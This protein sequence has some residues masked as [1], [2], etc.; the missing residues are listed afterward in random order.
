M[1]KKPEKPP[2]Q[3]LGERTIQYGI[4]L[5][6]ELLIGRMVVKWGHLEGIMQDT[7][8]SLVEVPIEVGRIVTAKADAN[9]KLQWLNAFAKVRL[10][11]ADLEALTVILGEIDLARDDR[12]FMMHGSWGTLQPDN[13]PTCAS[14]RAKGNP[15]EVVSETFS[16][17]RMD[18]IIN[19]IENGRLGLM[20]W[21]KQLEASRQ[22]SAQRPNN[23]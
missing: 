13:V 10:S 5:K 11:G 17:E 1:A 2:I 12:N 19:S 16:Y 6:A 21:R 7:L 22:K 4:S 14:V 20:A 18:A 8:W 3:P 9:T 23:E 15:T